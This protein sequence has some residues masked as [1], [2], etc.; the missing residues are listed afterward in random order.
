MSPVR[1]PR[2]RALE[3]LRD[4]CDRRGLTLVITSSHP[5]A[6][7]DI[8]NGPVDWLDIVVTDPKS[9]AQIHCSTVRDNVRDNTVAFL[10]AT[11]RE[12]RIAWP[13]QRGG[14]PVRRAQDA[15]LSAAELARHRKASRTGRVAREQAIARGETP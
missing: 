9:P 1:S 12:V 2:L 8:H 11:L 6:K 4:A 14:W 10:A 3:R 15:A 13:L 7:R 5:T